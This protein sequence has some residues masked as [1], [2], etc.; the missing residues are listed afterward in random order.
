MRV[1]GGTHEHVRGRAGLGQRLAVGEAGADHR[2]VGVESGASVPTIR[3]SRGRVV[4]LVED[5]HGLGAGG[6]GVERLDG[7]RA[8]AALDQRDV[9][10]AA[11]VEAGE[12]GRLAAAG[13]ARG[14]ARLMSTGITVPVTSPTPLPVKVPVSY[15]AVDRRQLLEQRPGRRSSNWNGSSVTW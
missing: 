12:V 3:P 8:G 7:E 4:A 13:A 14:G 1:S 9:V 5:D 6:L 2:D 15:V 10:G 11:E